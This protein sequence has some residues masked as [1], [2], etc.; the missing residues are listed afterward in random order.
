MRNG[1]CY[2]AVAGHMSDPVFRTS[3]RAGKRFT[4]TWRG[5]NIHFGSTGGQAFVDH[6]DI[7]KSR[8]DRE[9]Q[10]AQCRPEVGRPNDGWILGEARAL[11]RF[12]R[13]AD[14]VRGGG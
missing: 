14:G 9:A 10:G 4:L 12:A 2:I 5:K 8:L 3:T 13:P 6:K 11:G 1:L 7:G